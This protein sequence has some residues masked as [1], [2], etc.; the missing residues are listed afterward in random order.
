MDELL[1]MIGLVIV[2]VECCSLVDVFGRSFI[3]NI[4]IVGD[5]NLG[6]IL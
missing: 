6:K 2:E 3:E 4:D 5:G 1:N